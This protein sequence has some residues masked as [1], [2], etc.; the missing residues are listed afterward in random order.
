M[1]PED[2]NAA[3]MMTGYAASLATAVWIASFTYIYKL[4]KHFGY[5]EYDRNVVTNCFMKWGSDWTCDAFNSHFIAGLAPIAQTI[6]WIILL[7][8]PSKE[9]WE[10]Y[11]EW[12]S[13]GGL[14]AIP[15]AYTVAVIFHI[16]GFI[17]QK[18]VFSTAYW[19]A[20]GL[21]AGAL[22]FLTGSAV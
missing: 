5:M 14:Y 12:I 2:L 13:L 7:A 11:A 17:F 10:F 8:A 4:P 1:T 3:F 9:M 21:L 15:G 22:G 18:G 6:I 20:F 16:L 19:T